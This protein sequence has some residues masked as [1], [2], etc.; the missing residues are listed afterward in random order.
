M[1]KKTLEKP[2]TKTCEACGTDFSC[3]AEDEKCWCFEVDLSEETLV[4]LQD[5]HKGCL[6][7]NCL[8][9]LSAVKITCD[10]KLILVK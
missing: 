1:S 6:C 7:K 4:K 9:N 2:A 10:E 3:G 5:N 8:E